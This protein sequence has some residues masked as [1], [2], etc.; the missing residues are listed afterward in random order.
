M[1]FWAV[2][3]SGL[4]WLGAIIGVCSFIVSSVIGA[5]WV[6]LT[7]DDRRVRS[8]ERGASRRHLRVVPK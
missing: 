1:G 4:L 8:E 7:F 6:R 2:V 3:F 5:L